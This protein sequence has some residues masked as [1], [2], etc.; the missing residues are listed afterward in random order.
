M[1]YNFEFKCMILLFPLL[2]VLVL[3]VHPL[4]ICLSIPKN[5][6]VLFITQNP[7][8]MLSWLQFSYT[9]CGEFKS[10]TRV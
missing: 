1:P 10:S 6:F 4:K 8:Y 9:S 3:K 5:F 2:L 7:F